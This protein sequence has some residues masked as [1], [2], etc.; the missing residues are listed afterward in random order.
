MDILFSMY[1]SAYV[2]NFFNPVILSV[3]EKI[4]T[5]IQVNTILY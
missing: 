3:F 2:I 4:E 1:W 5:N